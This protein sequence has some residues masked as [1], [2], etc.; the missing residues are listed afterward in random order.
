MSEM[1]N[2][3][4]A[5]K[6]MEDVSRECDKNDST[7]IELAITALREKLEREEPKALTCDGCNNQYQYEKEVE[8]GFPSP[9]TSCKRIAPDRYIPKGE[10]Q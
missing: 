7:F 10:P 5:I 4:A 6:T 1:E 3:Q 2:L 8:Y 9:C